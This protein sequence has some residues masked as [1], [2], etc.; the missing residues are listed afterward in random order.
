VIWLRRLVV[1]LVL[2][3]IAIGLTVCWHWLIVHLSQETGTSSEA[4]R[5]YAY[6]SGFGS[7]FPWSLGIVTGIFLA[8]RHH[9]CHV[10]GCPRLGKPVEGTPYLACP[11]HHP[12][13]EGDKRGIDVSVIH[14]AHRNRSVH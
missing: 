9:N 1:F 7:V 4:S 14:E 2:V 3:L 6:W 5:S 11:A 10:K 13:H 8:Y 12:A